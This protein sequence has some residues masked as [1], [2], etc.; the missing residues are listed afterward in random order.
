VD[1][2]LGVPRALRIRWERA[3]LARATHADFVATRVVVGVNALWLVLSRPDLPE[4]TGFPAPFWK[5]VALVQRVRFLAFAFPSAVEWALYGALIAALLLFTLG[6]ATSIAGFAAAVLLYRFAALEPLVGSMGLLWFQCFTHLVLGLAVVAA[7]SGRARTS[8]DDRWS[9]GTMR[10]LFA[11][12]YFLCGFEK[13]ML[14]GPGWV[15]AENIRSLLLIQESRAIFWTPLASVLAGSTMV[16]WIIAIATIAIE[17]LFPLVLF[18][19]TAR[20]ILVPAAFIGHVG[21]ALALGLVFL[22]WP[23][24]LLFVDWATPVKWWRRNLA[25]IGSPTGLGGH[26]RGGPR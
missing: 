13:L 7:A 12:Y 11:L 21:I 23:L 18:S 8:L 25:K 16:C 9:V 10:A 26:E 22:N 17:L 1:A 4:L 6:R 24:L 14:A 3:W 19:S 5:H 20:R 2:P 15:S